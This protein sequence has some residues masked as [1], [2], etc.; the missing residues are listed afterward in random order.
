MASFNNS[1]VAGV[2]LLEGGGLTMDERA[3]RLPS[4]PSPNGAAPGGQA[5]PSR[6]RGKPE[7]DLLRLEPG[8]RRTLGGGDLGLRHLL[9]DLAPQPD[10]LGAAAH[11]GEIEPLVCAHV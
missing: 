7:R 3:V 4:R 5:R 6:M 11:G 1:S 2:L 10:R 8:P 9:G